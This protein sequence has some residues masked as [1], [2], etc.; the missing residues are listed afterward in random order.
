M[1]S[2]ARATRNAIDA[3]LTAGEAGG[4]QAVAC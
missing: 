1:P 4:E 2:P 3:A